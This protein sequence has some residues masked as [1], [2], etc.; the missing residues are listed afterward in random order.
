MISQNWERQIS[1]W[2]WRLV[3]GWLKV[4]AIL[5]VSDFLQLRNL[6]RQSIKYCAQQNSFW[7]K[8]YEVLSMRL[9][10][11]SA[12]EVYITQHDWRASSEKIGCKTKVKESW[13]ISHPLRRACGRWRS[14]EVSAR[15][16]RTECHHRPCHRATHP[17]TRLSPGWR[18]SVD[19]LPTPEDCTRVYLTT[20]KH[21]PSLH[22]IIISSSI[23]NRKLLS[24]HIH[25]SFG[26]GEPRRD[27]WYSDSSRR[28]FWNCSMPRTHKTAIMP[29]NIR[30]WQTEQ[31]QFS[32]SRWN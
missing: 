8:N 17:V 9:V 11:Y 1:S 24:A 19:T 16:T 4:S 23:S 18:C 30:T 25:S 7:C 5:P 22:H 6:P 20:N 32:Y 10:A 29:S 13:S 26:L 2:R 28:T 15:Q 12:I 3:W 31:N 14:H 21:Q 27:N